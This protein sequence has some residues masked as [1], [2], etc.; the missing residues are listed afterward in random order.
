M[1]KAR[2]L[3][4]HLWNNMSDTQFYKHKM[5]MSSLSWVFWETFLFLTQGYLVS[6]FFSSHQYSKI[7]AGRK[8]CVFA[9]NVLCSKYPIVKS[10]FKKKE[11]K[12]WKV[13]N[14]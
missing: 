6:V 1:E 10:D 14:I 4:Q 11:L 5:N 12:F 9:L 8:H 7:T 13:R 2:L 3:S